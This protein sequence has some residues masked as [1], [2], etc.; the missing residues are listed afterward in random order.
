MGLMAI[1]LILHSIQLSQPELEGSITI[2]SDCEGALG[3]VENIP[4]PWILT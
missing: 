1:H 2:H 4:S 3:M